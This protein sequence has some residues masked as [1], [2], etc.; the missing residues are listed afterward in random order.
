MSR[1]PDGGRTGGTMLRLA[2]P[3]KPGGAIITREGTADTSGGES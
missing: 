1:I 3:A 2:F